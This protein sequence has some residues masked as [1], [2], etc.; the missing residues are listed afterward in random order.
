MRNSGFVTV[1]LVI[2]LAISL[3]LV[4]AGE[5]V[6]FYELKSLGV[7]DSAAVQLDVILEEDGSEFIFTESD[8]LEE[9]AK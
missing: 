4:T 7:N 9:D 8:S 3:L 5:V 6:E 1:E 2:A